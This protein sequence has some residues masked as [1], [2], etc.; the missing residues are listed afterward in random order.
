MK[1]AELDRMMLSR[2]GAK[3]S[4]AF[5]PSA[6]LKPSVWASGRV[7]IAD[8]LTP[9]FQIENSPWL[10]DPL[11]AIADSEIKECV[12][13]APV[14]T[15]KTTMMEAGMAYVIAEDPGPTLLVGQTDDDLKDW[16]ETRL[17]HALNNTEETKS[18]FP[19][20]RHKRRKM[21]IL[22]PH[23]AL[24]MTGANLSGLQS[25]SMRRVWNDE[26]WQYRKGMLNE[27]RGRL[28]D[29]WNRQFF[30][31]SQA[32]LA[33]DDLDEAHKKT[34][35]REFCYTCPGCGT[36]Q[37]WKMDKLAYD[38]QKNE[39]GEL[40]KLTTAQTA[41]LKCENPECTHEIS[42]SPQRRREIAEAAQ[43]VPSKVGL[44]GHVGYH[45]NVLCNWRKPLWEI[46]L[47]WLDALDAKRAG[48]LDL[49]RQFIQKRLAEPWV[50]DLSDNRAELVG[51]GYKFAEYNEKE[52]V[53]GE[54]H[55]FLTVDKQRDHFW[56]VV[57]AWRG[58]GSSRL[59]SEGRLET[60]E[61]VLQTQEKYAVPP[62]LVFIDAQY[63]TD[64]V[65]KR[66]AAK[67]WSALHGSGSDGFR[68]RNPNSGVVRM[69]PFSKFEDAT[70]TNGQKA[71]YAFWSNEKIKDILMAHRRGEAQSWEIP[72]DISK[73]YLKQIDSEE[74]REVISPKTKQVEFRYVRIHKANHMF[75]AEAMQVVA[76]AMLNLVG[77]DAGE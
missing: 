24:F 14:G 9:K 26:A 10:R 34:D 43:Y 76:A 5:R 37:P 1:S 66:C 27:S 30:I 59:L 15:G 70:A 69:R 52:K 49:M 54:V 65:Y 38:E 2:L 28:H 68:H 62:R 47:L 25:K 39:I 77:R 40:D 67:D 22:F 48:S 23:M 73:E 4:R 75:D 29:R 31:M 61:Q 41:R 53:E 16:A 33:G 74:K 11:D 18:L 71:R 35:M 58:D 12:L 63:D 50:E 13:L 64:E 36:L 7:V 42:D 6:R 44:P 55:R 51:D 72:D 32:G 60:W 56:H 45:Y 17:S 21:Q 20:D 57:R 3:A 19:Q 46:V 8:G